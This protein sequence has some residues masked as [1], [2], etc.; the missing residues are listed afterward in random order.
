MRKPR[1]L[2]QL[3]LGPRRRTPINHGSSLAGTCCFSIDRSSGG[4]G[5]KDKPFHGQREAFFLVGTGH[6][7]GGMLHI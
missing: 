3:L 7:P 5:S 2:T 6:K 1:S 4:L